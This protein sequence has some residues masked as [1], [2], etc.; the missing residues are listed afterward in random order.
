MSKAISRALAAIHQADKN[1][2]KYKSNLDLPA[3]IGE[4]KL[5]G[6]KIDFTSRILHANT[7][8]SAPDSPSL[9]GG[10]GLHI[11]ALDKLLI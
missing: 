5:Y 4:F 1:S 8:F 7:Y 11:T 9:G 6:G 10:V 3:K 2:L